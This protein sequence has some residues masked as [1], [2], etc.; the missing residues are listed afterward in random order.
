MM[1][2]KALQDE[3]KIY[4]Q[5]AQV[6]FHSKLIIERNGKRS[7]QSLN[8]ATNLAQIPR[9]RA[10]ITTVIYFTCLSWLKQISDQMVWKSTR[11]NRRIQH[12]APLHGGIVN[13]IPSSETFPLFSKRRKKRLKNLLALIYNEGQLAIWTWPWTWLICLLR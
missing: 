7:M 4:L 12:T 2:G 3:H 5:E 11:D 9:K 13:V 6:S 1:I 10:I 8:Y